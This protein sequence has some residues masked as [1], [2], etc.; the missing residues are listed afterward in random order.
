ME[1][2]EPPRRR[3]SFDS[4]ADFYDE[5][6]PSPPHEVVD[7]LIALSHLHH[8]SRVLEIGCGT[9]QLSRPLAEVGVDLIAID[10]GPRLVARARRRLEAFPS[11]RVEVSAFEDWPLPEKKFDAV[12]SA[13]A[14]HWLDPDVRVAKSAHALAPG[15]FLTLLHVHHVR[16]GT[17]AFFDDTQPY[18][19]KWGLSDDPSFQPPVPDEVGPTYPE[20]DE[21]PEF[22]SVT[23]RRFEIPRALS[24]ESYVGGLQTDSLIHT[25]DDR[26]RRGFLQDIARLIDTKYDG[27]VERN[28]VYEL[29]AARR[30]P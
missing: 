6:R 4:V 2:R 21:L 25:L 22:G 18:Y 30:A 27:R 16:G 23:R 11:A 14:F 29:I 8:G 3:E 17:A 7:A 20:L 13:N 1:E 24:T 9:G 5:Y 12:V 26:A 10:L 19:V 28:F 15:G